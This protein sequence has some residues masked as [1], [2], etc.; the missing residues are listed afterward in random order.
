MPTRKR[1]V[2]EGR[3]CPRG[4]I[5]G[6]T[7]KAMKSKAANTFLERDHQLLDELVRERMVGGKKSMDS[8]SDPVLREMFVKIYTAL[9]SDRRQWFY[10]AV[11]QRQGGYGYRV[12]ILHADGYTTH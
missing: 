11:Y 7:L 8:F 6:K 3:E 2:Y 10:R 4:T 9:P 1:F 12:K 5:K